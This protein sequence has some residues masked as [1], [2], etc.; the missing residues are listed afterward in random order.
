MTDD[1]STTAQP[2]VNLPKFS[3]NVAPTDRITSTHLSALIERYRAGETEPLVFGDDNVPEAAIIPFAA[4]VRLLKRDH[5][6]SVREEHA[7]QSELSRRIQESDTSEDPGMTLEELGDELGEPARS[8]FR[9][10]LKD[11]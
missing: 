6:D 2:D 9:K 11:D 4:F 8:M 7:F 5:A 1:N 10:A 3:V